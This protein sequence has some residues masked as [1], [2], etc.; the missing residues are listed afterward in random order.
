M[1]FVQINGNYLVVLLGHKDMFIFLTSF[2]YSFNGGQLKD[3]SK[4]LYHYVYTT[5]FWVLCRRC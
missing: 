4:P 5:F 1:D 2:L 3:Q